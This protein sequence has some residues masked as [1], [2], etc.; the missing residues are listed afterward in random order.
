MPG[1]G[2]DQA[3]DHPGCAADEPAP[4]RYT[5][6]VCLGNPELGD[7]EACGAAVGVLACSGASRTSGASASAACVAG[8]VPGGD[9]AAEADGANTEKLRAAPACAVRASAAW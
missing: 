7:G 8:W 5:G 2:H 4:G 3:G 9:Q 6:D 1:V